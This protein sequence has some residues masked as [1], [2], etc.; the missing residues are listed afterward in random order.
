MSNLYVIEEDSRLRA[1]I[2]E[3]AVAKNIT[4]VECYSSESFKVKAKKDSVPTNSHVLC[5]A[6][7]ALAVEE[8]RGPIP[9]R[10][11]SSYQ[12][13]DLDDALEKMARITEQL[14]QYQCVAHYDYLLIGSST[15]GF[16]VVQLIVEKISPK[17]TIVVINQHIS[18]EFSDHM[19]ANLHET[20]GANSVEIVS[21][22]TELKP[23][24]IYFLKGGSDYRLVEGLE[25]IRIVP[26]QDED[27]PYHP[28]FNFLLSEVVK[29]SGTS[30]LVVL[31]GLGD[32][33]AT[34]IRDS[35]HGRVEVIVQ[36]PNS[37]KAPGMPSAAIATGKA[38]K[39]LS[40]EDLVEYLKE[41]VV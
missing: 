15:G 36:S 32:D 3:K 39:V 20:A 18:S 13:G 38:A 41:K 30:G 34:A 27:S 9:A 31:S 4:V 14:I 28:S 29:L 2:A 7:L 6:N 26:G 11:I 24:K 25:G 10:N 5:S 1:A 21:R 17:K 33:G 16:P 19:L 35:L 22:N 40:P 12:S 23:G 37:S 8:S